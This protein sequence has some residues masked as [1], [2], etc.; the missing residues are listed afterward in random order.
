MSFTNEYWI[1]L[2]ENALKSGKSRISANP[3]DIIKEQHEAAK[4]VTSGMFTKDRRPARITK[5]RAYTKR[6]FESLRRW[7]LP[8]V[9]PF[10]E[11]PKVRAWTIE[12][13][14]IAMDNWLCMMNKKWHSAYRSIGWELPE[15]YIRAQAA[16]L[17]SLHSD[18]GKSNF[19]GWVMKNLQRFFTTYL[20]QLKEANCHSLT[21]SEGEHMDIEDSR[22]PES[23]V[24]SEETRTFINEII[25]LMEV[26]DLQEECLRYNLGLDCGLPQM[27]QDKN[28]NSG[29]F[30]EGNPKTPTDITNI[31][32]ASKGKAPSKTSI[33]NKLNGIGLQF[34]PLKS[35]AIFEMTYIHYPPVK[36]KHSGFDCQ[37][38]TKLYNLRITDQFICLLESFFGSNFREYLLTLDKKAYENDMLNFNNRSTEDIRNSPYY[39]LLNSRKY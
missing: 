16:I 28:G 24:L 6:N 3:D 4:H 37:S 1:D 8:L 38:S 27:W 39:Q 35:E 33:Q 34:R 11:N 10:P 13:V 15:G 20:D 17:Y 36:R 31:F 25:E 23:D 7:R 32:R 21:S 19:L 12:E 2:Y 5:M 14:M 18:K 9:N 22:S 26:T 29:E 30:Q